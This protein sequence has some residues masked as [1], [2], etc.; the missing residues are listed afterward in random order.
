MR[1]ET[2][3]LSQCHKTYLD[4]FVAARRLYLI[5][6]DNP[7]LMR[8]MS[9]WSCLVDL[10]TRLQNSINARERR[11]TNGDNRKDSNR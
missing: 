7:S 10:R 1:K 3:L 4:Y 2:I 11:D 8:E 5:A 9:K 6:P